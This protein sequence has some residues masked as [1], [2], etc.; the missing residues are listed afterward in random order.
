MHTF[1]QPVLDFELAFPRAYKVPAQLLVNIKS[2]A[3]RQR[4]K[5]MMTWLTTLAAAPLVLATAM[6][7]HTSYC[8]A[9]NYQAARKIGVP[10]R[11]MPIS[12][13]NPFWALV[14]RKIII[15]LRRYMG[16]NTF[17]RFNW[18][19]WEI[20]DRYRSFEEMGDVWVLVNPFKNWLYI[21]DPDALMNVFR[22]G[23][24]FTRPA[25]MN[26]MCCPQWW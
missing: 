21:N 5:P 19:G 17:T 20:R 18:R 24:D 4:M 26:G 12:P 1:P 22:R 14:D 23:N 10:I 25:W 15:F 8:I 2:V 9:R 13:M 16:D 3:T 6:I 11:I 7:L